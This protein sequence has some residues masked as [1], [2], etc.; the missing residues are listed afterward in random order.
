MIYPTYPYEFP[1]YKAICIPLVYLSVVLSRNNYTAL[2]S[3][4]GRILNP[5]MIILIR[6]VAAE[7][8]KGE[9]ESD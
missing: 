9:T 6:N 7:R 5:M 3:D 1:I 8:N 2:K 4:S